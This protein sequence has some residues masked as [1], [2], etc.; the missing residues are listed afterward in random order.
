[1]TSRIARLGLLALAA[2][3]AAPTFATPSPAAGRIIGV[4]TDAQTG[5]PLLGASARI[6]GTSIG[7]STDMDGRFSIP[8]VPSGP[9][10][11]VVSY[12]GYVSDTLTVDVPDGGTVEV[13][14]A[15]SFQTL[16]GVEV[17]AQV[18]GQ[19][20]AINEQFRDR[21][22][23]NVVSADRIQ[24]LPDNNAAESIGRLPGVAIQR[25][26]GEANK[27][28][29]RGL[30][31]KFNNVTV[32]GVRLAGTD[33]GDRSVDLSLISSNIL[34]GIEV[35]KAIT[36][37]MDA[38]AIGGAVNLRLRSAQSGLAVDVLGQGGYTALQDSYDNYKAVGTVSNRFFGDRLGLIGTFNADR[39]DRSADKLG[40]G[41]GRQ[42]NPQTGEDELFV[43]NLDTREETIA[44]SRAGGSVLL[45]YTVPAGRLTANTFFNALSNE[46][47]VRNRLASENNL[48]YNVNMFDGETTLWTS[49]LG[50]E[51]DFGWLRYDATGTYSRSETIS[52]EDMAWTFSLD[53]SRGFESGPSGR[54]GVSPQALEIRQDS[55]L[56][57]NTIWVDETSLTENQ[58]GVQA[59][60]QVPFR[61]GS[62][63]NGY[64]KTG[65]KLRWLDRTYDRDRYGRQGLQYPNA[66]LFECLAQGV[67]QY[68]DAFGA[69]NPNSIS[70]SDVL[71]DY[72]RS[73]DFFDG[74]YGLGLVPDEDLLMEITRALQSDAC[75]DPGD[76][77]YATEFVGQYHPE[78]ITSLGGDYSGTEAYQAAYV[79][80]ELSLGDYVTVIP[81]VRYERD[82]TVYDGQRFR[83]ITN[84][85][86]F[87]PPG[88]FTELTAERTFD[89]W[90]PMVHLDVRPLDWLSVRLARTET[91][92][93]PNFNQ[94]APIT[95]IDQFNSNVNAANALLRPSQ[96]TNYDASLQIVRGDLGLVGVSGFH[97]TIDDLVIGVSIPVSS[98]LD[99]PEG[100]NIPPAWYDGFRPFVTTDVNSPE[101]ATFYGYELEWQTNFSYLPGAL[102]GIVLNLNYTRTFSETTYFS[103]R[104]ES[105]LIPGRPPRQ[106]FTV[107]DTT[108]AGR[109]PDQA[110]H[111]AN[112]TLGYDYKG[113]STRLSYLFQSNTTAGVNSVNPLFDQFVGDYSRFDLSVRQQLQAGIELFANLNNLN[114]RPDQRYTYQ[115]SVTGDY[116]FTDDTLSYRELYGFTV[117]VGARYRF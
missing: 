8:S 83:T 95:S 37:D 96:A 44:R 28:A 13:E 17:T 77:P 55:T 67:P 114:S 89:Y 106:V 18:A 24:E 76:T 80:A 11:L 7:A 68:T 58:S 109:V 5:D 19:L 72:S 57:L 63:V 32:N 99:P 61:L 39:Y 49:A 103:Y 22:V 85:A 1:M 23:V 65:G 42:S 36:P 101:P 90:L 30:S 26:G 108:R 82:N 41:Y 31:P 117:D 9:Q 29:I 47:L 33:G 10:Q 14:A 73:D 92:A 93:R 115:N 3:V 27:V 6:A 15:L 56:E 78:T 54:V 62:F 86:V 91:L 87:A 35:R 105:E 113:F 45:D 53:G 34:D 50:V 74:D 116:E 43:N 52:P 40:I 20:A 71:L 88:D 69:D 110:A 81:G 16:E 100:T 107:V 21:T 25:S 94:Y 79:M 12:V 97:K 98:D 4:V 64:V 2:L 60:I 38:D 66:N 104:L 51:Q 111:V 84:G 75:A 59:N 48:S 70:V 112:V 46:G 102:K